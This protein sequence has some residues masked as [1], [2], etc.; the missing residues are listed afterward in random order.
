MLVLAYKDRRKAPEDTK[1]SKKE[2]EAIYRLLA[3]VDFTMY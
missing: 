3:E 1:V 2:R